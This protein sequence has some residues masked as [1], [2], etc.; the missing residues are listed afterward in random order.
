MTALLPEISSH[1]N[2]ANLLASLVTTLQFHLVGNEEW[3]PILLELMECRPKF[4]RRELPMVAN[5]QM[6]GQNQ[7]WTI[8]GQ[9]IVCF[10]KFIIH[11]N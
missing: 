10:Y 8:E 3:L 5:S 4:Q 6:I 1:F 11:F 9:E 7:R 2:S